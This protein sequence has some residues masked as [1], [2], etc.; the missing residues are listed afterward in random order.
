MVFRN[1]IF[2][3]CLV[4]LVAGLVLTVGQTLG[5]TPIIVAAEEYELIEQPSTDAAE[6]HS[7]GH[8]DDVTQHHHSNESWAPEGETERTAYT[9]FSNVLAGIG[10][11]AVLLA[12]MSQMQSIGVTRITP[13]KGVIWG[14]A[15][16]LAVFVSPGL[17]LPP[18]IPG[19]EAA[20]LEA[21]QYWWLVAVIG[22]SVGLCLLAFAPKRLKLVG[23]VAIAVPHFLVRAPHHDGPAFSHPEANVVAALTELHQSFIIASGLTNLVF[24][25]VTG[26][27]CAFLFQRNVSDKATDHA[28]PVTP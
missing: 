17:G 7:H 21:R 24:W 28:S 14:L 3:A 8:T 16:Y 2:S 1:L 11:A 9:A 5:V 13:A 20:A 25:L 4:G 23:V 10:F 22:G 12:V 19:V 26:W 15:G 18:E 27:L 6:S